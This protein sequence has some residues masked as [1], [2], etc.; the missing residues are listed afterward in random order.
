MIRLRRR[1]KSSRKRSKSSRGSQSNSRNKSPKTKRVSNHSSEP[2]MYMLVPSSLKKSGVITSTITTSI[3]SMVKF[4]NKSLGLTL[5][6]IKKHD[7]N[8]FDEWLEWAD[9]SSKNEDVYINLFKLYASDMDVKKK[10]AVVMRF[11]ISADK[12]RN[13]ADSS[14]K[15]GNAYFL[16]IKF[17]ESDFKKA[18]KLINTEIRN[19]WV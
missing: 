17:K 7:K 1:S 12:I 2:T 16:I 14:S 10:P 3:S 19:G 13:T 15:N 18:V 5:N 4:I 11:G 6:D 9:A 8:D